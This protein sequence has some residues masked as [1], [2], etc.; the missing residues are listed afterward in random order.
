MAVGLALSVRHNRLSQIASAVD[1]AELPG[2]VQIYDGTRPATG[3]TPT[4]LLAE[5][6]GSFPFFQSPAN[7]QMVANPINDDTAANASGT[8]T[9]WRLVDG[10]GNFVM[11][12]D[13]GVEMTLNVADIVAGGIVSV[14]SFVIPEGNP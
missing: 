10:L 12:G 6:V 14:T 3:G 11:D 13:V 9:W 5:C 7:G 4:N 1:F 8:P 2:R